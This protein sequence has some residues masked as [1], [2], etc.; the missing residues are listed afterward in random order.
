MKKAKNIYVDNSHSGFKVIK[1]IVNLN[2]GTAG[3]PYIFN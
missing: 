2:L 3:Y 1:L